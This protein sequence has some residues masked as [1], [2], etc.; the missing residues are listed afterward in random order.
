MSLNIEKKIKM[1]SVDFLDYQDTD[2]R[3]EN[4]DFLVECSSTGAVISIEILPQE[5]KLVMVEN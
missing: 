1:F 5:I 3:E 4:N 2:A